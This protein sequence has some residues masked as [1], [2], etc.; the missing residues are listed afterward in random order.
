M[1]INITLAK[2]ALNYLLLAS[3]II[4]QLENDPNITVYI[5]SSLVEVIDELT[6]LIEDWKA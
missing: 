4:N 6:Q 5:H 2:G 1:N 3:D